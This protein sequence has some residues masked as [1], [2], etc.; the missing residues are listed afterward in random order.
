MTGCAASA[1]ASSRCSDHSCEQKRVPIA[2]WIDLVLKS[3]IERRLRDVI[4]RDTVRAA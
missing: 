4:L 1:F 3:A 2:T